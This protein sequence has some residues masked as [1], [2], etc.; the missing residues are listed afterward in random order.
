MAY[1]QQVQEVQGMDLIGLVLNALHG[2]LTDSG[3]PNIILPTA[4]IVDAVKDHARSTDQE[5]EEVHALDAQ[6]VGSLL[7]RLGFPKAPSHGRKRSW[8]IGMDRVAEVADR[9]SHV[10]PKIEEVL[11]V[12]DQPSSEVEKMAKRAVASRFL[13]VLSDVDA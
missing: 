5:T 12:V 11:S 2:Q 9:R 6:R 1:Q 8:M 7:S 10:L 3:E 13:D 4:L